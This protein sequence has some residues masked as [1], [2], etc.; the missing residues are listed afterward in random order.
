[1]PNPELSA[2]ELDRYVELYKPVY[3]DYEDE[4]VGWEKVADVW[5]AILPNYAFEQ[6]EAQRTIAIS[7]VPIIMRWRDD[8]D[9]RWRIVYR[10]TTYEIDGFYD[11]QR[12]GAQ[13]YA[14]C[15]EIE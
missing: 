9:A 14:L 13:L 12:R 8:I 10:T 5:A 11:K 7:Q 6:T 1:M 15:K 2:G 3:N 4:I